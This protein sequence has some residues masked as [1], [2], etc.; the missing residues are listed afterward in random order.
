MFFCKMH[1]SSTCLLFVLVLS[2]VGPGC[3]GPVEGIDT[4]MIVN[5]V[6]FRLVRASYNKNTNIKL[7]GMDEV[8]SV[9]MVVTS[10][11]GNPSEW[12]IRLTNS[13]GSTFKPGVTSA[14]TH[15]GA[16]PHQEYRWSF[17]VPG[18]SD[19]FT[20]HLPENKTIVLD[21]PIKATPPA[22]KEKITT[23]LEVSP[24]APEEVT[25]CDKSIAVLPFVNMSD[26]AANEYFSDGISE[27]LLNLLEKIPE[28]RVISRSSAF[29]YKGKDF[30]IADVGRELNVAYVLEG[31]VRKAGNKVRITA[32]L[33]EVDSDTHQWSDTYD[34][35][36]EDIFAIQDEIVAEV[37]GHIDE[38]CGRRA[39][40]VAGCV[41]ET[42]RNGVVVGSRKIPV[43]AS[44]GGRVCSGN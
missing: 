35:T 9:Y 39:S 34:R 36:L 17:G 42:I 31:S 20:L 22:E 4:P 23:E 7:G 2:L 18:D 13:K 38:R 24:V 15:P 41:C 26:D 1:K 5:G 43:G 3:S 28:F 27:E 32:Q 8:F 37:V 19:S 11:T 40:V 30:K 21:A 14:P 16:E 6:E 33:I 29:S 44:C 10:G 12:D 25:E